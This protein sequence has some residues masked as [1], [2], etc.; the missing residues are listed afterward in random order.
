[1]LSFSPASGAC[2]HLVSDLCV[3]HFDSVLILHDFASKDSLETVVKVPFNSGV[4]W[5]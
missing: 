2:F 5:S 1:M 3:A 4:Y